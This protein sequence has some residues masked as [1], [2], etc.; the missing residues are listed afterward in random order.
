MSSNTKHPPFI[1]A[2][3]RAGESI[4]LGTH[5]CLRWQSGYSPSCFSILSHTQ[6]KKSF[7]AFPLFLQKASYKSTFIFC[8][9]TDT[10]NRWLP[11]MALHVYSSKLFNLF[12]VEQINFYSNSAAT[13]S[14][15]YIL[16]ETD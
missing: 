13:P 4:F 14:T 7:Y 3:A 6:L 9:F 15:A 8:L 11:I 10:L 12:C 5:I 2:D 1:L 16:A